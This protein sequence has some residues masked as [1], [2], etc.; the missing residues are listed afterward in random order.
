[1]FMFRKQPGETVAGIGID[2]NERFPATANIS[3]ATVTAEA[4][5]TV[6]VVQI[7]DKTLF[8]TVSGGDAGKDYLVTFTATGSDGSTRLG[9]IT[10]KVEA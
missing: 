2:F 1:M 8:T 3:N 7:T 10:I 5:L 6:A 9:R 4:G